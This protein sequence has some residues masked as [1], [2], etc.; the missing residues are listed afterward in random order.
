MSRVD[1]FEAKVTSSDFQA[2]GPVVGSIA[3]KLIVG[4]TSG[5]IAGM[6][7]VKGG[8]SAFSITSKILGVTSTND[9]IVVG[10]WAYSRTN[11]GQWTKAPASGKTLQG[12][13]GSGI[14]LIDEGV[15][16]KFGRQLHRLA[17]ADMAGVDLSA[18]GMT[19]GSGQENL[20]VSSLSFWAEDD[21]TPAGLSIQA[22]L[23]Q[24]ILNTPS[25]ETVTLDI[26][27]DTLSGVTITTPTS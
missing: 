13:V 10:G 5:S 17:V 4:S 12:F 23:D 19:A 15:E 20:I 1:S 6:F 2:Q 27:I 16:A 21:G 8:D 25:H 9:N 7:K 3:V 14:V 11:G 22:S 24:K 18:F 26:G